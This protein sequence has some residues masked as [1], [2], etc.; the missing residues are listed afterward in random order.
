MEAIMHRNFW[1]FLLPLVL[2]FSSCASVKSTAVFY[3]P[4]TAGFY[5]VKDRHAMIP[6]LNAPPT[7]PYTEIGRL[8][9]QTDRDYSFIQRA[10]EYNAQRAGADAII[11]KNYKNWS[12]PYYYSVPTTV[13]WVPLGGGYGGGCGGWYGGDVLMPITSPGYSGVDYHNFSGIDVRM[14]VFK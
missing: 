14:I 10:I 9:F 8:A 4:T 1:I 11:I 12:M 5:P 7:R 3:Q 2:L 13:T 6:I